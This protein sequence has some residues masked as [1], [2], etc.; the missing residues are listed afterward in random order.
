M[1]FYSVKHRRPVEVPE[2]QCKKKIYEVKGRGGNMMTRYA[3]VAT[4]TVDGSSVNL[5]K[6][7][8]K[9]TFDS[10]NCPMA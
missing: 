10:L 9:P 4:A 5:T 3:V 6:F 7:I 8:S 2:G 1:Q